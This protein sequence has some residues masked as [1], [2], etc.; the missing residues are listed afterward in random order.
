[1]SL[2]TCAACHRHVRAEEA[3]CPF[4]GACI[5]A[6]ALAAPATPPGRAGRAAR[7]AFGAGLLFTVTA[8][9]AYRGG[10]PAPRDAGADAQV[11]MDAGEVTDDAGEGPTD[12]GEVGDDAGEVAHDAGEPGEDAG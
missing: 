7:M 12:A 3:C 11:L 10:G 6:P 1:M 2:I 5:D 9:P 4:C 8:C